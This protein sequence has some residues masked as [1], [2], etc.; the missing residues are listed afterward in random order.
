MR[1][2]TRESNIKKI[3]SIVKK[4]D[5]VIDKVEVAK[6]DVFKLFSIAGLVDQKFNKSLDCMTKEEKNEADD[7][8]NK[9][10]LP[11]DIVISNTIPI[12]HIEIVVNERDDVVRHRVLIFDK[13]DWVPL[14]TTKDEEK[15]SDNDFGYTYNDDDEIID[16]ASAT[17]IGAITL[18]LDQS[19]TNPDGIGR[20][21]TMPIIYVKKEDK[22]ILA[23]E[24]TN[25][26]LKI[27]NKFVPFGTEAPVDMAIYAGA[28]W[29][30][31]TL[32]I[33]YA[34][35]VSLLNPLIN[36]R[37]VN[38]RMVVPQTKTRNGKK[39]TPAKIKYYKTIYIEEESLDQ[40]FEEQKNEKGEI[41]R[42]CLM[43]YVTGHW[44]QYKDGKRIFIQGYWKG[45]GRFSGI[46]AET[47]QREL[48]LDEDDLPKE[49][50]QKPKEPAR[51]LFVD[52]SYYEKVRCECGQCV[53]AG[54][55]T[56]HVGERCDVCHTLIM[57]RG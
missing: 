43:W 46:E 36:Y 57:Y 20:V 35:E 38:T 6:S 30:V 21:V 33:W 22:P 2:E 54:T 13:K 42:H 39:K 7:A 15:I 48:V 31:A 23:I 53:V 49:R 29:A 19:K 47:R 1:N 4:A 16:I 10:P 37:T 52:P 56:D 32:N 45:E 44:R 24:A 14:G 25:S 8:I 26:Y 50:I 11:A 17:I 28:E 51:R 40:F 27:F 34:I 3:H 9:V 55:S 41:N 5:N 12:K 18:F